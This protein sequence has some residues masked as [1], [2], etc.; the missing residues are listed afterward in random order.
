MSKL[1]VKN[2]MV[3]SSTLKQNNSF[4]T[5]RD[6]VTILFRFEN[7]KDDIILKKPQLKKRTRRN[8]IENKARLCQHILSSAEQ[9]YFLDEK[10]YN[11]NA[12]RQSEESGIG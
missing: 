11:I 8:T 9:N 1:L 2:N 7:L 3:L 10:S 4:F 5:K 6:K 12:S